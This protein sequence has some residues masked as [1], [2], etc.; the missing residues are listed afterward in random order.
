MKSVKEQEK[1]RLREEWRLR[2]KIKALKA[3]RKVLLKVLTRVEADL[4]K[5][6]LE[7]K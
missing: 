1:D 7:Q 6:I 3:Q 4:D 2:E 5:L